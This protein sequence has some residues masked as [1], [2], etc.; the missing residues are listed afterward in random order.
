MRVCGD[1][2]LRSSVALEGRTSERTGAA[3]ALGRDT[4]A[5][6]VHR[7]GARAA[8]CNQR[9]KLLTALECGARNA[10]L[11]RAQRSVN[12]PSL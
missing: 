7:R 3:A 8:L 4:R 2:G 10:A 1:I 5:A 9:L 11:A 12:N 6:G